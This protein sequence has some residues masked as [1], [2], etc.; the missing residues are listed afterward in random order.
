MSSTPALPDFVVDCD[1][2][3]KDNA[4]WRNKNPPDY[5]RT[6]ADYERTKKMTHEPGSLASVVEN[7]VKNWEIEQSYKL[8]LAD[9]RTIDPSKYEF[10]VNGGAPM[11]AEH[12]LAV[13]S[14]NGLLAPNA[15]YGPEHNDF[16]SSHVT[17]KA[18]MPTF[19]WEVLEVYS[20][21]PQI[22]F[23]WRH[24]GEMKHDYGVPHWL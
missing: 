12:M 3:L 6:R 17:F 7:L 19:A 10:S 14:Y 20:G 4:K 5:S 13:G 24:W 11:S 18:M 22:A 2:V 16:K 23:R 8:D 15:F 9:W 1:A 21:P